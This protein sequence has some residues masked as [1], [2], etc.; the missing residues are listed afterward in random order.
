MAAIDDI[1]D[2]L[3]ALESV[4]DGVVTLLTTLSADLKA[5]GTDPAKLA[6]ISA[7]LDA[8]KQKMADA[9]AANTPAA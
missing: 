4:Q 2:K 3:T 6:A 5:A 9:I 7:R 1:G 8:D